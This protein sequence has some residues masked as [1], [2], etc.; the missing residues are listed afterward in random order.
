MAHA[1][2]SKEEFRNL[3]VLF[4]IRDIIKTKPLGHNT[5]YL[6]NGDLPVRPIDD[7]IRNPRPPAAVS[8]GIPALGQIQIAGNNAT[9]WI[10]GIVVRIQ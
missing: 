4:I 7:L 1:V 10:L 6:L 9:E 2:Q 5:L 3:A 8:V